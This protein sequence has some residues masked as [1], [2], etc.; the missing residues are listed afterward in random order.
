MAMCVPPIQPQAS[1][2]HDRFTDLAGA[3]GAPLEGA[4]KMVLKFPHSVLNSFI[5][6]FPIVQELS[7]L[8]ETELMERYLIASWPA[9]LG[10]VPSGP[11]AIA[12][13]RL[14]LQVQS[15][16][17]Q[18]AIVEVKRAFCLAKAA[19]HYSHCRIFVALDRYLPRAWP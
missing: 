5:C 7:T 10:A 16:V 19:A 2:T 17:A 6:S 12:L 15:P 3:E 4:E 9:E 14:V 11:E 1:P 18:G 13:M 8:T